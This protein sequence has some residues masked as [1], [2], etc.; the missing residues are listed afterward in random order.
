MLSVRRWC[1]L[2]D[3]GALCQTLVLSV[4]DLNGPY[5]YNCQVWHIAGMQPCMNHTAK[6]TTNADSYVSSYVTYFVARVVGLGL[7]LS[8]FC[9]ALS[10][11]AY[12]QLFSRREYLVP[13]YLQLPAPRR[14][15]CTGPCTG[16]C[17]LPTT[18]LEP[19]RTLRNTPNVPHWHPIIS[20]LYP[21]VSH[22]ITLYHT[23]SPLYPHC[24]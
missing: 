2:S 7:K 14:P 22:C 17:N 10:S 13:P 15:P 5:I 6:C 18:S 12:L 16:P 19:P 3:A 8:S 4:P 1:F 24:N 23:V 20:P 9:T 21:T 11:P